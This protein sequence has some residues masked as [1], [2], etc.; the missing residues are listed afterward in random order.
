MGV[1]AIIHIR[2]TTMDTRELL[3][4]VGHPQP[5]AELPSVRVTLHTD[6]FAQVQ[7]KDGPARYWLLAIGK[8]F[9]LFHQLKGLHLS[10]LGCS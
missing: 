4:N 1:C 9:P 3:L 6:N 7:G 8:E 2:D 5:R 10:S